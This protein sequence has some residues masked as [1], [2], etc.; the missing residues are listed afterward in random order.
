MGNNL[1]PAFL[2]AALSLA[3]VIIVIKGLQQALKLT[4]WPVSHQRTVWMKTIAV[5]IG[6]IALISVLALNNFFKDFIHLPPKLLLILLAACIIILVIAFS[7]KFQQILTVVPAHWLVYMQSFRIGVEL[8]LWIAFIKN[9]LPIQMTF[10]GYNYDVLSGLL[11]LPA[12]YLMAHQ[13]DKARAVGI[14]YNS[15]GLLLLLNILVIAVL[16]MPT[17]FRYFMNEPSNSIVAEFPFVFLPAILV[18]LALALHVFSLRQ[19]LGKHYRGYLK[20]SKR[21]S[22]G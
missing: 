9:L 21:E 12:G 18:V 13:P 1:M 20:I 4:G 2:F 11:A 17:P 15:I 14:V 5:I 7:K 16:S 10:E 3:C 19:L 6:W 22:M 8:L